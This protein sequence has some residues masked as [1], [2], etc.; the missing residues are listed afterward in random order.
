MLI[1]SDVRIAIDSGH[2]ADLLVVAA[3]DY[4]VV[5]EGHVLRAGPREQAIVATNPKEPSAIATRDPIEPY[6]VSKGAEVKR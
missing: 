5:P 1:G 2:T 3:A 4:V 6:V